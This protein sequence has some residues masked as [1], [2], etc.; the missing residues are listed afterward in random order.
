MSIVQKLNY[1]ANNGSISS[2]EYGFKKGLNYNSKVSRTLL[3]S[4]RSLF[5]QPNIQSYIRLIFMFYSMEMIGN[6]GKQAY[7]RTTASV[8][9]GLSFE[10]V[11]IRQYW[12][13]PVFF[14]FSKK[15]SLS[16]SIQLC[17]NMHPRIII[18][19]KHMSSYPIAY[20]T[21][22]NTNPT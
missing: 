1:F 12:G 17:Q 2:F 10:W 22:L 21:L 13:P 6:L 4:H 14:N 9:L 5:D 8:V 20:K 19:T 18:L 3:K 15:P 16:K 7:P 11:S